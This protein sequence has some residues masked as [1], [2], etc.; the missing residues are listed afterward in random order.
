MDMPESRRIFV[1]FQPCRV[2][3]LFCPPIYLSLGTKTMSNIPENPDLAHY[4]L[5]IQALCKPDAYPHTTGEI[6]L[7]ETHISWVLLTGQTV[8][9]I[10]KPVQ[11]AFLDFSTLAQRL[12]Y[13]R[14]ELRLNQRLAPELYLD[15]VPITGTPEHPTLGGEAGDV[16][17]YAIKMRQFPAGQLLSERAANGQLSTDEI[18]QL[19]QIIADFHGICAK[20]REGSPYG[21]SASIKR[22]SDENFACIS[23]LLKDDPQLQQLR[24]IQ[25]WG[26]TQWQQKASLMQAR[27]QQGFV[28]ECHGDLHLNN[29]TLING[30]VTLFDCIEFNAELRWIDVISEIA[31]LM[32]DL[33]HVGYD[34]Y[35]YRALNR[36]LQL[37]G[38]YAGL[39]LLRYYLVYRALVRAKLA[40]LR[41]LQQ[42]DGETIR[43]A[44][45]E[46]AVYAALAERFTQSANPVLII[47]HGYSGSGKSFLASQLAAQTGALQIRSD[48]ERKRLFGYHAQDRTDGSIYSPTAGQQTYQ[49]LA[50]LA[51]MVIEAG[52]PVIVD[53]TFLKSAQRGMF[54]QLADDCGVRF[55]ILAAQ[56]S[57]Q[58]LRQRVSERHGDASEATLEVLQRQLQSAQALSAQE[59]SEAIMVDTERDHIPDSI[60]AIKAALCK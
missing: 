28:R 23:P 59:R 52:F 29:I 3:R 49:Q 55:I 9:K 21:D 60:A 54:R 48:V 20:A 30:K 2:G 15:I 27:K 51:K 11:F 4:P 16:I 57:A 53:A 45:D 18:D 33:L 22:W 24:R 19:A 31:F 8:Y 13:C 34:A 38:D 5:L 36:Y 43:Q 37:T 14:E 47:T 40:L 7:V 25:S 42:Q 6:R 56:A 41:M 35:A 50:A 44:H 12:F 17:E 58:T 46:Y 39:G 32:V 10:K 1:Y 26:E